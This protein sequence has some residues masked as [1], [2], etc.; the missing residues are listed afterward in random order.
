MG[1]SG[2]QYAD[3]RGRF[4]PEGLAQRRWFE[5]YSQE[6]DTVEINA[7][8][9]RLPAETT[10]QG[11]RAKAPSGFAY[12]AKGSRFTTH[13]IKIGGDLLPSSVE[14]VTGRL[15]GLGP[16]LDVVLWQLPPNLH[17]DV[18][19]LR[20]FLG[21]LPTDQRHAVEFRHGSWLA[22]DVFDALRER[23][24]AHVWLSSAEMPP[25]RTRTADFAYV[26]FHGLGDVQYRYDYADAELAPWVEAVQAAGADELDAYVYF[27]NDYE[28]HA[29]RNAM[30][31]RELVGGP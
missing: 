13:R 30:R 21:L 16:T 8:F 6:F 2:W 12:A 31:F 15:R 14:L 19:R 3:W 20:R 22:D 25:D 27:N 17:R 28:A 29:I 23:G 7:S 9:Y 10:I 4:Y 1:T 5:R 11:W 26:R 24:A 18:A